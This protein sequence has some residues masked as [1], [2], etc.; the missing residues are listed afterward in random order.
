MVLTFEETWQAELALINLFDVSKLNAAQ[1]HHA[2]E[3]G[4]HDDF[5]AVDIL[6]H[7]NCD[8]EPV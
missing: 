4:V 6:E 5:P 8:L 7:P 1:L 3:R 2:A